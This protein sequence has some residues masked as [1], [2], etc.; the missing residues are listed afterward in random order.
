MSRKLKKVLAIICGFGF[1]ALITFYGA[2]EC[3]HSRQ[4]ATRGKST[5]GEVLETQ[6]SVHGK[7]RTH[8]YYV[9]VRFKPEGGEIVQKNVSVDEDVFQAAQNSA[10]TRVFYLAEDPTVC[11]VGETV[12]LRYGHLLLG[13]LALLGAGYLL[14][15]FKAPADKEEAV[16]SIEASLKNLTKTKFEYAPAD[17][18]RFRHLD[19]A[20]YDGLQKNLEAQG[21]RHVGDEENLSLRKPSIPRTFIRNLIGPDDATMA[22]I[23]HFKPGW[24]LGI[25]GAKDAKV[26]DLETW[27]SNGSFVCTSNAE[28]A[29]K[30]NTPPEINALR[31]PA[32][33]TWEM[34]LKTH[35]RRVSEHLAAH[36]G[37]TPVKLKNMDDVH[38][39][40]GEQQ[41]IKA[42]FRRQ[43]GLTKAELERMAGGSSKE[44]NALH[45]ALNQ[46]RA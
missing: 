40:Q 44:V 13:I 21:C 38:R 37:V 28:M 14:V 27:F 24:M 20:F 1:G 43:T 16:E 2:K 29:G 17:P 11:A 25:L 18:R 19:L 22:C 30:L 5:T 33:T 15:F 45:D 46:R 42:E 12:K 41:R 32:A 3:L 31:L 9:R 7:L 8:S 35:G 10:T 26:L 36:A 4:L 39:A 23:Y 6:D 34:L